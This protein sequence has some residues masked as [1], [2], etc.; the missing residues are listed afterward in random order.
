MCE[1]S[2]S[3]NQILE[4]LQNIK[5]ENLGDEQIE[6]ERENE[7]DI[8]SLYELEKSDSSDS[9]IDFPNNS[10]VTSES[11]IQEVSQNGTKWQKLSLET[12]P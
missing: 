3:N 7:S 2:L 9:E 1:P 12:P 10:E 6:C 4:N 5:I 8:E 11:S